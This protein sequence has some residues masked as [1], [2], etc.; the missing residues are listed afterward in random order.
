MLFFI[1][2][3]INTNHIQNTVSPKYPYATLKNDALEVTILLPDKDKGYYRGVRFDWSG[4][5]AQVTYDHHTYFK[6]LE[7][8][9]FE[10]PNTSHD[11]TNPGLATGT[12]EEFRDPLGYDEA[13]IGEPFVKVG[14]GVLEKLTNDPYHW[15]Y[16]YKLIKS[17]EWEIEHHKDSIR[18]TQKLSTD[19][20]YAY[21]YTKTIILNPDAPEITVSHSLKNT[22]SKTIETNPYCHNYFKFDNDAIGSH[23]KLSFPNSIEPE[24]DFG[25]KAYFT[26]NEL[27]IKGTLKDSAVVQGSIKTKDAKTFTLFN[28]K[29]KTTTLVS[30]DV[31]PGFFYLYAWK[32]AYCP[33]P[34]VFIDISRGESFN[35]SFSYEFKK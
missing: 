15:D 16:R 8:N 35:W 18:F 14:V 23:Y 34:M 32:I 33:E 7:D 29:S 9:D 22:G 5:I 31:A 27:K 21:E 13:K 12:A 20:G 24:S 17:A 4:I 30:Y 2:N 25:S 3:T 6:N 26:Q 10:Y 19:F 1:V 11:P 28:S